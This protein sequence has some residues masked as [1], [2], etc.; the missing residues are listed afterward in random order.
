MGIVSSFVE[1][2]PILEHMN[3][4]KFTAFIKF[5][6]W[7]HVAIGI[8]IDLRGPLLDIRLPFLLVRIGWEYL[9]STPVPFEKNAFGIGV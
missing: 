5:F 6:G 4:R 3:K 1:L 9:E 7:W 8:Q 2:N